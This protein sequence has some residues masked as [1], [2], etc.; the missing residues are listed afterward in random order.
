M[1]LPVRRP[2]PAD[3]W[4]WGPRP[5]RTPPRG[6]PASI[7]RS[8]PNVNRTRRSSAPWTAK[9]VGRRK[10]FPSSRRFPGLHLG[11]RD[12]REAGPGPPLRGLPEVREL[13]R[14][15]FR[16]RRRVFPRAELPP[17]PFLEDL[18]SLGEL[19]TERV[20]RGSVVDR[21]DDD[22]FPPDRDDSESLVPH[23]RD[24]VSPGERDARLHEVPDDGEEA[25]ELLCSNR[26]GPARRE[27]DEGLPRAVE[28][29]DRGDAFMDR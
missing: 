6:P 2:S 11:P 8:A 9:S 22:E 24:C 3:S 25:F 17:A 28:H 19:A 26:E 21:G 20:V 13:V 27:S 15:R 1:R 16:D 29:V 23:R 12:F 10:G 18:Q 4:R 7:P 5:R 14:G